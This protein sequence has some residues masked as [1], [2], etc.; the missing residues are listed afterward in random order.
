MSAIAR[1]SATPLRIPR[2]SRFAWLM[3]LYAENH[4]RLQ[5]L[6]VPELLAVG[7]HMS[8]GRDGLDLRIDVVE[9]HPYTTEL[10]LFYPRLSDG[11]DTVPDPSAWV[12]HYRDARQAEVTHCHLGRHWQNVLGLHPPLATRIDHRMR[13]NVFFNKWLEYLLEQG[14]GPTSIRPLDD[15]A[16]VA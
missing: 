9:R 12:R 14:H 5:R 3:A 1:T 15:L 10:R 8:H 7:R 6:I 13:M 2:L 4:Q 16:V 11:P